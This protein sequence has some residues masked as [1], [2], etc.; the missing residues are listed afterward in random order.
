MLREW[1]HRGLSRLSKGKLF[2]LT[3]AIVS[4]TIVV[5]PLLP[6]TLFVIVIISS[7]NIHGIARLPALTEEPKDGPRLYEPARFALPAP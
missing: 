3:L 4:V 5:A 2:G 1:E 7:L 6:L